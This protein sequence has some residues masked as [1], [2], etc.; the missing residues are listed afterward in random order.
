MASQQVEFPGME[1][2]VGAVDG[3]RALKLTIVHPDQRGDVYTLRLSRNGGV[4]L[5]VR[6]RS[7]TPVNFL[8]PQGVDPVRLSALW[9][10]IALTPEEELVRDALRIIEPRLERLAFLG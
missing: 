6:R 8:A 4:P 3:P 1:S 7:V 9:D 5:D 2:D 10:S